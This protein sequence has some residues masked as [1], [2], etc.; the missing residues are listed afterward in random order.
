MSGSDD[1]GSR[2]A[3]LEA[4]SKSDA[5]TAREILRMAR[6]RRLH[7]N[8]DAYARHVLENKDDSDKQS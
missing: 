8:G 6:A 5:A 7:I 2:N 4:K 1:D 3:Y